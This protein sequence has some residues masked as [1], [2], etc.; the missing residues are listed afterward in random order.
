[1][2][3]MALTHG[4]SWAGLA[5]GPGC[6]ALDTQLN[7]SLVQWSCSAGWN[8]LPAIAAV[9]ALVSF[10]GALSSWFAWRRHDGPTPVPEQ[11]GHSRQFLSGIG[12]G[13]GVLFGLVIAMQCIAALIVDPCLR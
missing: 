5:L 7:Y 8:P 3:P 6:W 4:K 9:L 10:A 11:D 2:T 12:V 13:A 1:V